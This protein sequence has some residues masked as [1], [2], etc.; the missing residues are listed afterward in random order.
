MLL[1]KTQ[2]RLMR[3]RR[4]RSRVNGTAER[5]RMTVFRSLKQ[6]TVQIVDDTAGKT[7]VAAST[8]EV[9]AGPNVKG[10]KKLG[11]LIA[12]KAVAKGIS[13]IVFDRNAYAYHGRVKELADAARAGGLK[14]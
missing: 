11:E 9:K 7:L 12:K 2:Q 5:P 8:K 4:I 10:A 14:F 13:A 3:K 1:K 6:I